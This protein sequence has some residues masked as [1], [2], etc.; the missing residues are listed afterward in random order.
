MTSLQQILS[1]FK[2]GFSP[3]ESQFRETFLSFWHKSEKI[4]QTQIFG[5]QETIESATRGLIYQNPVVNITDLQTAY[6]N[7]KIGWAAM[8]TSAGFIYSFN[9]TAW[10]NTGLNKFPND[11]AT[12]AEF[13]VYNVTDEIP[14]TSGYYT[15][16]TARAA[17]PTAIRKLG[18][19]ITYSTAANV[20]QTEQFIG[21]NISNWTV[22]TNWNNIGG[23]LPEDILTLSDLDTSQYEGSVSAIKEKPLVDK[24]ARDTVEQLQSDLQIVNYAKYG[25]DDTAFGTIP[26]T[27]TTW[28]A[29]EPVA[30]DAVLQSVSFAKPDI[31]ASAPFWIVVCQM[32]DNNGTA[33]VKVV[34][35]KDISSLISAGQQVVDVSAFNIQIKAGQS[36]GFYTN[37]SNIVGCY[38]YGAGIL[39]TYNA[40]GVP[41]IG[42]VMQKGFGGMQK[43]DVAWHVAIFESIVPAIK[44]IAQRIDDL[45]AA[46]DVNIGNAASL[47]L[48]GSS[49]TA[50]YYQSKSHAWTERLNDAVDI[51]IVNDGVSSIQMSG[52]MNRVVTNTAFTYDSGSN[53]LIMK[54]KFIMWG[55]HANG[56][57]VG[58][59]GHQQLANAKSITEGLGS[60][61]LLGSEEDYANQP[62]QYELT[63]KSFAERFG[64]WYSPITQIW[65]KCFPTD[66]PYKGW[67]TSNHSGFRASAPYSIH[68]DMLN[69]LPIKQSVKMFKVRPTYKSG[70]PAITDLVYD[71]REQR[72]RFFTAISTGATNQQ[73]TGQIDNLDNNSYSISG[74]TNN[75]ISTGEVSTMLRGGTVTFNKIALIEFILNKVKITKGTFEVT[76]SVAPTKVY[77]AITQNNSQ[78]YTD[79]PRTTFYDLPFMFTG[80]KI[81]ADINRAN[82]D[83]QMY[84]KVRV[85]VMSTGS[86]TLVSPRFYGYDGVEKVMPP[87][88][89][90]YRKFGKE[91]MDFTDFVQGNWTLSG[92]AVKKSF[93]AEI[94]NYTSYNN[95]KSHLEFPSN[96][97]TATKTIT[98]SEQCSRV[99]VR[100]VAQH[101]LKIAT[102][103]FTGTA[104]EGNEYIATTPQ[105][106]EYDYDY[107]ILRLQVNDIAVFESKVMQGWSELYFEVDV[108]PTDTALKLTLTRNNFV[109][110]SFV[111]SGAP[112]IIHDVSV[113]KIS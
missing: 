67:I 55:N 52:N 11:V 50:S 47:L 2:T 101:F 48:Q 34:S 41:T 98:L 25:Y 75:G 23:K 65:R 72:L 35:F 24:L 110:A 88:L 58:V 7:A 105:A 56:T 14:L 85:I 87:A 69:A 10:A 108:T 66:N 99:A 71:T 6:P 61:C 5:L 46:S 68:A 60:V 29:Y 18:I 31:P 40:S 76:G 103:R 89:Y 102:T 104:L 62:K 86:F 74:G 94:A 27:G 44:D 113:Q 83:F 81:T 43:F 100:V 16:D 15:S 82:L 49:L 30:N 38:G 93:P 39:Q 77:L 112:M 73:N 20:W 92:G 17:V 84:D 1:W 111:N 107:G 42:K 36:F 45:G 95:Q 96:T 33:A 64:L 57:P 8:V 63:Y 3:S 37:A 13:P 28:T 79:T 53:P 80:A 21:T 32:F 70:S 59:A 19:I 78:T 51:N 91:L 4:P 54:P 90:S 12:R 97:A 109:D 22:A 9:G 26:T 106:I